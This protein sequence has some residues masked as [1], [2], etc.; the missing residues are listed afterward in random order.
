MKVEQIGKFVICRFD[1]NEILEADKYWTPERIRDAKPVPL[2]IDPDSGKIRVEPSEELSAT[3]ADI[4]A[5]PYKC[6]GKL[7]Y[8]QPSLFYGSAQ[9]VGT[10]D[11]VLTAAHCV[12]DRDTK[13]WSNNIKF[14]RA[15]KKGG[16]EKGFSVRALAVLADW[17]DGK[18][19]DARLDYGFLVTTSESDAGYL[20]YSL[21][22]PE[23]ATSFGYP[24]NISDGEIMQTVSGGIAPDYPG[25]RQ[26]RMDGNPMSK[27]SSG[28]A[29]TD[30]SN[31]A[32]GVNATGP[33]DP[34]RDAYM[35]S[36]RFTE[37]FDS[38]YKFVIANK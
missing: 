22:L 29:W 12:F 33:K 15:Y 23:I 36:P 3:E 27:G 16:Y 10:N 26:I 7:A 1:D 19:V 6:G 4:K 25:S 9:F 14:M 13:C 2:P 30:S 21:E 38:L 5:L 31:N 32:I 11:V 24:G 8:L 20:N 17:V 28:G 35:N 18:G 34:T 37:D